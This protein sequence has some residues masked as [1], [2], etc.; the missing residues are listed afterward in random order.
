MNL[1]YPLS[2]PTTTPGKNL[3]TRSHANS[4]EIKSYMYSFMRFIFNLL[5]KNMERFVQSKV[6]A[7]YAEDYLLV[8]HQKP[9]LE[10]VALVTQMRNPV[11]SSPMLLLG[12]PM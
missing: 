4:P 12:C 10:V 5:R 6:Y 1:L 2:P 8:K 11:H 9:L 7:E 3:S